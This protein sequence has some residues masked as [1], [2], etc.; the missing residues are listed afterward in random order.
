MTLCYGIVFHTLACGVV[1]FILINKLQRIYYFLTLKAKMGTK[2]ATHQGK[3]QGKL[4]EEM[5]HYLVF[6]IILSFGPLDKNHGTHSVLHQKVFRGFF[7][8]VNFMFAQ[9]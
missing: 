4:S 1:R 7:S 5:L 9:G 8:F 6:H 2:Q 3:V